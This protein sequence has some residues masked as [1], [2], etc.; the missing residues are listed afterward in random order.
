MPRAVRPGQLRVVA[1][2]IS[3][4]H[5]F[6]APVYVGQAVVAKVEVIASGRAQAS[7]P[8]LCMR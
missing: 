6:V 8:R 2:G 1:L 3:V 5:R 7:P 4:S